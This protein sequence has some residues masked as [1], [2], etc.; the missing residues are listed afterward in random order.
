M[1][2]GD[3]KSNSVIE[4][5]SFKLSIPPNTSRG[6]LVGNASIFSETSLSRAPRIGS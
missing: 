5:W 4:D 1:S 2:L 3:A 6:L